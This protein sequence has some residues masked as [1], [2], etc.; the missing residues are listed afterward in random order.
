MILDL[1]P[2]E[3]IAITVIGIAGLLIVYSY[4]IYPE[5]LRF[6]LSARKKSKSLPVDS[7]SSK[8]EDQL[9]KVSVIMA[10]YNEEAVLKAKI[11]SVFASN[12]P[13]GK[14]EMLIGSDGSE[15]RTDE[16]ALAAA[17]AG[18]NI[19]LIRLEGRNGKPNVLNQLIPKAEGDI[20][21]L[22]DA[23]I[24]FDSDMIWHLLR[25]FDDQSVGIVAASVI[26][27]K[28]DG[29]G[30]ARQEGFYVS[31]ENWIKNMEGQLWGS[32]MG[33]FG[34]A[35]AI[36]AELFPE[37]RPNFLME[38]FY[39]SMHVLDN[40][41]KIVTEQ[42]AVCKEDLPE[43]I[44][45]EYRRKIRISTGNFQNLAAWSHLLWKP[46]AVAFT[47]WSH[48]VLRWISPFLLLIMI[49][50]NLVLLRHPIF[51]ILL[52][53]HIL[54]ILSPIWDKALSRL[55]LRLSL[56]RYLGYFYSMNLALLAG[57]WKY[58]QGVRSSAWQPPQR[59]V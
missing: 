10:A 22:T 16:I 46:N 8:A 44:A 57:F 20:Y 52:L 17:S 6:M 11:D 49:L 56:L 9:P 1:Q 35:Y 25:R 32:T 54:L 15:D 13:S 50:A 24:L 26:N 3:W 38:D 51:Q 27:P 37:L 4:L 2:L 45:E 42:Q 48:K 39:V 7:K 14:L 58:V 19:Q 43:Q 47:F 30:I 55:G 18:H 28:G 31:R 34:A 41:Y 21:I 33:A 36:R 12:Y 59:N 23:N 29:K 5:L 53:L 40:G